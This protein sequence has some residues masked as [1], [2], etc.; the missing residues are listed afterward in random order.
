MQA[1]ALFAI[2]AFG[3]VMAMGQYTPV[4][5]FFYENVPIFDKLRWP[6]KFLQL[7]VFAMAAL[8]GLGFQAFLDAGR[9]RRWLPVCGLGIFLIMLLASV[10]AEIHPEFFTWLTGG[11]FQ[12]RPE[13]P[14]L[15]AGLVRDW[16]PGLA[17]PRLEPGR[18]APLHAGP[19][20]GKMAGRRTVGGGAG[21]VSQ[22]VRD[23][24]PSASDRR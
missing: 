23:R 12:H 5:K 15:F 6:S 18:A 8:A 21:G 7:V 17:F 2:L 20:R 14:E 11:A 13:R 19:G 16:K 3:L 4:Y 24:A 22:P 1:L 10:R 9:L